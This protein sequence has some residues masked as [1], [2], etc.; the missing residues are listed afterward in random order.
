MAYASKDDIL[1]AAGGPERLAQLVDRE[2]GEDW[3]GEPRDYW[4]GKAQEWGDSLVDTYLPPR[5]RTPLSNVSAAIRR[6]AAAEGIYGL[7]QATG[8]V[9][10]DDRDAANERKDQLKDMRDGKLWP[11]DPLPEPTRG[12]QSAFVESQRPVTREKLKGF[13]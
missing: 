2:P 5:F 12:R 3:A 10:E 9:T 13:A 8:M 7:L 1:A 11:S 4:I 6:I